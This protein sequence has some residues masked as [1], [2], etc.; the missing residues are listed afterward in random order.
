MNEGFAIDP[1][2]EFAQKVKNVGGNLALL[3]QGY[4][5]PPEIATLPAGIFRRRAPGAFVEKFYS[6]TDLKIAF[7]VKTTAKFRPSRLGV[8]GKSFFR[9]VPGVTID[10][11]YMT[12]EDVGV[13]MGSQ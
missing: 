11:V 1:L 2:F 7:V 9:A 4:H 12:D 6:L 5:V 13:A 10:L 8:F 3:K